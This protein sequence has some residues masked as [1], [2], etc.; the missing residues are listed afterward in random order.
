MNIF[1]NVLDK[2]NEHKFKIIIVLFIIVC[3]IVAIPFIQNVISPPDTTP[4]KSIKAICNTEYKTTETIDPGDIKV[5]AI[6]QSGKESRLSSKEYTISTNKVAKVGKYTNVYVFL[7]NNKKISCIV[8]VPVIRKKITAFPC[9]YPNTNDVK[10][11]LYNNGELCFEGK[12][13]IL[14]HQAGEY[15]W[16]DY[17][18]ADTNP[19]KAI[20]FAKGV[21]PTNLNNCFMG[22]EEL[23]YSVNIPSSVRSM[24]STFEGCTNLTNTPAFEKDSELIDLTRAFAGCEKLK[25]PSSLPSN[26]TNMTE[27]FEDCINLQKAPNMSACTKLTNL[28]KA[29]AGCHGLTDVRIPVNAQNLSETF[30]DCINLKNMPMI[31]GKVTSMNATFSGCTSLIKATNIPKSVRDTSS[32]FSG[33]TMLSGALLVDANATEYTDMFADSCSSTT[34][35]LSGGSKYLKQYSQTCNTGNVKY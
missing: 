5:T 35:T 1:T 23:K 11:V 3:L 4:I 29:F 34:L 8:K 24:I 16:N 33:C 14:M 15:P 9:G 28:S 31:P 17:E 2:L 7:K 13:D 21:K 26:V 30:I 27:A 18:E 6:H 12:G 19:I 20:S 10:A 25:N 32:L 22:L